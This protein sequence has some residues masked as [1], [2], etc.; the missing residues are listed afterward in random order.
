MKIV[1]HSVGKPSRFSKMRQRSASLAVTRSV[2]VS[3]ELRMIVTNRHISEVSAMAM[4][5][6]R[7]TAGSIVPSPCFINTMTGSEGEAQRAIVATMR[8]LPCK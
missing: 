1:L 7:N 6:A 3:N 2:C 5:R 8:R 4:Y